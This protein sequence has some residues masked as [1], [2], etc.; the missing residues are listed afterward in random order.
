MSTSVAPPKSMADLDDPSAYVPDAQ[1]GDAIETALALGQPLLLT[2]EPG[3]GKTSVG[4]YV[5]WQLKGAS[6][7]KLAAKS[8]MVARD[9]LYTFDMVGRFHAANLAS[10][11]AGQPVGT[12]DDGDARHADEPSR[13]IDYV[14]L[15]KA[16]LM[17][18]DAD[19][20]S[21]LLPPD[22]VHPGKTQSVVLIDEIDKAPR[23]VPNDL[24]SE[25]EKMS[26]RVPELQAEIEADRHDPAVRPILIITSNSEK[27]LPDAFLRRCVYFHMPFPDRPRLMEIIRRRLGPNWDG[28]PLANDAIT[29]FE[30]V[31]ER[32]G[33]RKPP[34][35]AELLGLLLQLQNPPASSRFYPADEPLPQPFDPQHRL[36]G[37]TGWQRLARLTLFKTRDDQINADEYFTSIDWSK[38]ATPN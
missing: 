14:G 13:Y 28:Q 19:R 25:L 15:G 12:A 9:F 11:A 20:Y 3:C 7:I 10:R 27:A 38:R 4:D 32:G 33:L 21:H 5:A 35:T 24:L 37:N 30:Q 29:L 6:A 1:L 18:A 22:F 17:A 23:D 8:Q 34:G 36:A 16:I 31:R 2:G 26:F